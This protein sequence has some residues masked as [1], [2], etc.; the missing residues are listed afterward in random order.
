MGATCN[1]LIFTNAN[2]TLNN[3]VTILVARTAI[4]PGA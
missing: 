2:V 1:D 4:E 3:L